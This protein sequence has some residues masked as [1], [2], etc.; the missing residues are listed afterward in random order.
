MNCQHEIPPATTEPKTVITVRLP[1]SLHYRLLDMAREQGVSLNS[2][3]VATLNQAA[4]Q[5]QPP[6]CP[7]NA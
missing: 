3:C 7:A 6:C 5:D 1:R 2:L 4:K